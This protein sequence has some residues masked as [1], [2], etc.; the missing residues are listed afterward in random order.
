[1]GKGDGE[2]GMGKGG[3]FDPTWEW[4]WWYGAENGGGGWAMYSQQILGMERRK[5]LFGY[6]LPLLPDFEFVKFINLA[7]LN[8]LD[9]TNSD[10]W[11]EPVGFHDLT[12][13]A[14]LVY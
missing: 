7:N 3:G 12:T 4:W 11:S 2:W 1:M 10:N 5:G 9:Y 13:C 6:L 8:W 14:V